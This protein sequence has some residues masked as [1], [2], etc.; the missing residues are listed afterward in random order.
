MVLRWCHLENLAFC[1]AFGHTFL[2]PSCWRFTRASSGPIWSTVPTFGSKCHL[3]LLKKIQRRAT[4]LVG[5]ANLTS[6]LASL[7]A[8]RNV[9]FLS[10]FYRYFCGHCAN[11]V[12]EM[13]PRPAKICRLLRNC[14]A[15][16]IHRWHLCRARTV[17]SQSSFIVQTSREW[18]LLLCSVFPP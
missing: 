5:N 4:R 10:M 13:M 17:I 14:K 12:A 8:R 9:S 7:D 1:L 11:S 2:P 3:E 6:Q 18:N 15:W 16:H